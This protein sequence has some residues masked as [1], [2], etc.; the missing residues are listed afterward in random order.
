MKNYALIN[1]C[2]SNPDCKNGSGSW[3]VRITW[4]SAW[5]KTHSDSV[6]NKTVGLI[7]LMRLLGVILGGSNFNTK[8][9]DSISSE[10]FLGILEST[11]VEE[12]YFSSLEATS[13][14]GVRIFQD[15]RESMKI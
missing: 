5:D 2:T 11:G 12:S 13:K 15:L 6:L 10:V 3:L 9:S 8:I 14:T 7:A 4:P 1:A